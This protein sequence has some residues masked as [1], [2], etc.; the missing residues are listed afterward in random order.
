MLGA[1]CNYESNAVQLIDGARSRYGLPSFFSSIFNDSFSIFSSNHCFGDS[2]LFYV[3]TGPDSVLWNFGDPDSGL[4]NTSDLVSP[5][6]QFSA[7]GVY[8]VTATVF[9]LDSVLVKEVVVT[10]TNPV[11][12]LGNDTT[13]CIGDSLVLYATNSNA[14]YLWQDSSTS[15]TLKVNTE[16]LYWVEVNQGQCTV[17]DSVTID[18]IDV[19]LGNDVVLCYGEEF[20][21]ESNIDSAIYLWQDGSISDSLL[22]N[23]EGLYWIEVQKDGCSTFDSV[24]VDVIH[25]E[26][27][28]GNDST[29]C[30]GD[31]LVLYATNSNANYLWQDFSTSDTLK[32][33]TEGLYWV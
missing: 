23:N 15:D 19:D 26:L 7:N 14:T 33:N 31:S 20:L 21:F 24:L 5:T 22:V 28:F 16:G 13:L 2:S 11:V 25:L 30:N 17:A 4:A 18:V 8:S 10:I 6:H 32:V 3:N 12:N 29:L 27:N 9:L 1:L